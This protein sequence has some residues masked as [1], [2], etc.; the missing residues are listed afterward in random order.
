[1]KKNKNDSQISHPVIT[2]FNFT[3]IE[4][5]NSLIPPICFSLL[6]DFHSLW[7]V[8]LSH[9]MTSGPLI[10]H[11][12]TSWFRIFNQQAEHVC[13][14]YQISSFL[15]PCTPICSVASKLTSVLGSCLVQSSVFCGA[16]SSSV[17]LEFL[18]PS[19]SLTQLETWTTR[20]PLLPPVRSPPPHSQLPF[21]FFLFFPALFLSLHL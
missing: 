11:Y 9:W 15:T 20:A 7:E 4:V 2:S 1:M 8:S 18:S 10:K 3:Q 21:F 6:V 16:W 12:H 13:R 14:A 17:L 19:L 5:L